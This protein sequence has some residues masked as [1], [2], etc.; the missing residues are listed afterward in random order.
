MVVNGLVHLRLSL[1]LFSLNFVSIGSRKQPYDITA[2]NENG[3]DR[4]CVYIDYLSQNMFT[5]F[6]WIV[7]LCWSWWRHQMET[8]SAL[9][10]ICAGNSPVP[11]KSPTQR[12]VTRCFD[13][14]FDLRLNKRLSKQSWGWWF[15][16]P[17]RPLLRHRNV[18]SVTIEFTPCFRLY[19]PR[20]LHWHWDN[21]MT[22]PMPMVYT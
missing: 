19:H 13:V 20:L 11:G 5:P 7:F 6:V 14:F 18:L 1:L 12:P 4:L 17:S 2:F 22:A 16:T 15:E 8:L 21:R 9:L 10:T 3:R